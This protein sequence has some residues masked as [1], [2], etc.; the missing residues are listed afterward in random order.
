MDC[1][2]CDRRILGR[3]N[4]SQCVGLSQ[5]YRDSIHRGNNNSDY[6][7]R[8]EKQRENLTFEISNLKFQ[9]QTPFLAFIAGYHDVIMPKM[10]KVKNTKSISPDLTS[11]G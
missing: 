2:A 4:F 7:K 9:I 5:L 11:T 8:E 6:K 1:G 3:Y 10:I